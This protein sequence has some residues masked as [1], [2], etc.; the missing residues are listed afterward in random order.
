MVAVV[1]FWLEVLTMTIAPTL[2]AT[3]QPSEGEYNNLVYLTLMIA[4]QHQMRAA[5]LALMQAM[6]PRRDMFGPQAIDDLVHVV[7]E[8]AWDHVM[9]EPEDPSEETLWQYVSPMLEVWYK[10]VQIEDR[11]NTTN[12]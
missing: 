4:A 12:R 1:K 3:Y 2:P 11:A 9:G 7:I 5:D 10:D 8:Y 6:C